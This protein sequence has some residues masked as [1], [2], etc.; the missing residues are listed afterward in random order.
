MEKSKLA[1]LYGKVESVMLDLIVEVE[2]DEAE[3]DLDLIK[4]LEA[5]KKKLFEI[6]QKHIV[7]EVEEE[8]ED[9]K[10][11]D[12]ELDEILGDDLGDDEEIEQS[13]SITQSANAKV[14][15]IVKRLSEDQLADNNS[16][17]AEALF[18]AVEKAPTDRPFSTSEEKEAV[19]NDLISSSE[20]IIGQLIST[21]DVS[22]E[23]A[24]YII[25]LA[26]DVWYE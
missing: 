19:R 26:F 9:E 17:L 3:K 20:D 4:D 21:Y 22:E 10:T 24:K 16:P 8:I 2:T 1:D 18:S 25:G 14:V 13:T 23:E 5:L 15:E 6:H 7:G 12:E 11:E